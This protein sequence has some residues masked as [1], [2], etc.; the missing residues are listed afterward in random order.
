M[1]FKNSNIWVI[2]SVGDYSDG[3]LHVVVSFGMVSFQHASWHV[4]FQ[5]F[6]IE[7]MH[8]IILISSIPS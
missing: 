5:T 6:N 7:N 2:K 8:I 4:M 3:M 1:V